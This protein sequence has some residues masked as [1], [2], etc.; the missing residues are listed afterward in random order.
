MLNDLT[1]TYQV[2]AVFEAPLTPGYNKHWYVK[3]NEKLD[4]IF[5]KDGVI[6]SKKINPKI[7]KYINKD[8]DILIMTCYN[9]ATE[10]LGLIWAKLFRI[11]YWIEIDG[12]LVHEEN[13][14]KKRLKKFIIKGAIGYISSGK[15]TDEYLVHYGVQESQIYRYPFS[16]IRNADLLDNL[17]SIEEK[18]KLR[19]ELGII[20]NKIAITVGRFSYQNGLGK[21]FD[22]LIKVFS[23]LPKD[24]T[25]YIIGGTPTQNIIDLK[26][27][28]HASN[29]RF[30][31][32]CKKDLLFKYYQ[33]SD[34][35]CLQTRS[36]AWGLVVNEAMA[37]GLP[38]ITTDQCVAGLNLIE[39]GE[40]GYI[41]PVEDTDTVRSKVLNILMNDQLRIKMAEKSLMR[42]KEYTIENMALAH[43]KVFEKYYKIAGDN[44]EI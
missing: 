40:N 17:P 28:T 44:N 19:N 5:L 6:D 24:Y 43:K 1:N 22:I 25:L 23:T 10:L 29:V 4:V 27:S 39:D 11:P 21:G 34:V 26:N 8:Q 36:D 15:T 31:D 7:L 16:S 37:N 42:I 14:L 35:F 41:V 20:G 38:V 30:V 33:A 32:F 3:N 13:I 12:A 2:Q 9:E 18:Y